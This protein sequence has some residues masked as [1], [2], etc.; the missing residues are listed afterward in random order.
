MAILKEKTVKLI[1]IIVTGDATLSL[2]GGG[3]GT[4]EMKN[5]FIPLEHA[6]K[7][8]ILRAVND[9]GFG[10]ENIDSANILIFSKYDDGATVC[11]REFEASGRVHQLLFNGW[12]HLRELGIKV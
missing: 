4:I 5:I 2:W 10:C 11:E 9:N 12:A 1:G 7:D 3:S 8:N 6:T